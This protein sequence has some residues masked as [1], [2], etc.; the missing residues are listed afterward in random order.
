VRS[1]HLIE[2]SKGNIQQSLAKGRPACTTC[3]S[4]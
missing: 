1:G 4:W 3:A 2:R